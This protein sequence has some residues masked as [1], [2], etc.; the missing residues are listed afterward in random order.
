MSPLASTP[1]VHTTGVDI[2]AVLANGVVIAGFLGALARYC[3]GRVRK[4][5]QS[6]AEAFLVPTVQ[7]VKALTEVVT[8]L[9]LRLDALEQQRADREDH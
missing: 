2:E 7:A 3:W 6:D 1:S 4:N 8:K 5:I 9:G